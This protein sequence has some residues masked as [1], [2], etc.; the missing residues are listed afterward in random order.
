M[1]GFIE[2][3]EIEV[4][5]ELGCNSSL[6]DFRQV[7]EVGDRPVVVGMSGSRP[8]FFSTGV[9]AA[10]LSGGGTRPEDR[11]E[12]MMLVMRGESEGRQALTREEGRGSRAQVEVFMLENMKERSASVTG[13]KDER[14]WLGGKGGSC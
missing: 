4:G 13:L 9:T 5:L 14:E 11:E 6:E 1:E 8:G 2:I 7:G 12:L 3:V 10:S